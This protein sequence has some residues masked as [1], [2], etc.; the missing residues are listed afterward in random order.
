MA[1]NSITAVFDTRSHAEQ[2]ISEL[3]TSG[4]PASEITLLPAEGESVGLTDTSDAK[5]KGFWASLEDL[6]GGSEDHATY[7]ESLR[8]GGIMVT[9]RADDAEMDRV[10]DVLEKHGSVDLDERETTWRSE[11]WTGGTTTGAAALGT[12]LLGSGA[13]GSAMSQTE[14]RDTATDR[15]VT[16]RVVTDRAS[17]PAQGVDVALSK[18]TDD[19]I[20]VIEERLDVGKRSV[21]RG[22]VR[23]RT[24]VVEREVSENI[25][26]HEETVTVDRR[27]VDRPVSTLAVGIDPFQERVI[28]MEE[29]DE[30]AVVAKSARVV[31]EIGIRKDATDRV[32]TVRDTVRSTKVD[33]DDA[34]TTLS[35]TTTGANFLTE[36]QDNME[37][38]GSDGVHV[39]TVDHLDGERIKLK[40]IDPAAGGEHHYLTVDMIR[41]VAGKIMLAMTAAEAKSRW[42]PAG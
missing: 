39:G 7:A 40:K 10:V 19:A 21:S 23:I 22:K 12:G 35:A 24:S 27:V 31:E 18:G 16:D 28:E 15:V 41:S 17:V 42:T 1:K 20:Q 30:E 2:A 38:V 14:L 3:K 34:R 32:E 8:R 25:T 37:V 36:V 26:L 33:I 4:V 13:V 29:I 11:G 5:G 6:F 9:V